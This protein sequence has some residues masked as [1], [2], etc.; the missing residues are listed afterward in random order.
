MFYSLFNATKIRQFLGATC[1]GDND[2]NI[3]LEKNLKKKEPFHIFEQW[4]AEHKE[5]NKT[6]EASV[7]SVATATKYVW[8]FIKK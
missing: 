5:R 1:S 8:V 2:Q 3:L 4:F 7:M 6:P